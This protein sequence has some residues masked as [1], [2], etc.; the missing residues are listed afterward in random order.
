MEYSKNKNI[1][2]SHLKFLVEN[3]IKD[4]ASATLLTK[5]SFKLDEFIMSIDHVGKQGE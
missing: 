4:A 3:R 1:E 5:Q 2:A